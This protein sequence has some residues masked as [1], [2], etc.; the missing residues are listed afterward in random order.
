MSHYS[1]KSMPDAKFE[2]GSFSTFGDMTSQNFTLKRGT[3]I[4]PRKMDS[5]FLNEILCLESF[6]STQIWPPCQFQ[7]FS[8]REKFSFWKF[9]RRLDDKRAAATPWLISFATICSQ[10]VMK[11][12]AKVHKVW[13]HRFRDFWMAAVNLV[14][15]AS[16]SPP[17]PPPAS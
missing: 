13:H 3:S 9:L 11:I 14:I 15:W 4:Y 2:S 12:K 16:E 10:H 5:T 1:H 7:Q 8:G 6:Y 17:P